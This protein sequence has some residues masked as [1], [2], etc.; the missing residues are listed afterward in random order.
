MEDVESRDATET[1]PKPRLV[2]DA[3][4]YEEIMTHHEILLFDLLYYVI[5]LWERVAYLTSVVD[6]LKGVPT[7]MTHSYVSRTAGR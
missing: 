7:G 1:R 4:D 6:G 5:K 3:R 2:G